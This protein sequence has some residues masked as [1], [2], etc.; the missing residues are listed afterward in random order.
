MKISAVIITYNEAANIARC[1]DAAQLVADEIIIVDSFSKDRT[2]SI[3]ETYNVRFFERKFDGYGEQKNWGNAQANGDFILSLDADEILSKKLIQDILRHKEKPTHQAFRLNRLTNFSGTWVR[4]AGWYPD[5]KVRLWHK[6]AAVWIGKAV[7]E[8]LE[9]KEGVKVGQLKGDLLHYSF[10]SVFDYLN[11]QN[12]YAKL[13]VMEQ[14][15]HGKTPQF[16][17]SLLKGFYKFFLLYFLKL[18]FVHGYHGFVICLNG[19]G[20]YLINYAKYRQIEHSKTANQS[21]KGL[22]SSIGKTGKFSFLNLFKIR[23][24]INYYKKNQLKNLEFSNYNDLKLGGIAAFWAGVPNV[25]FNGNEK[26]ETGL[27]RDF[28]FSTVVS[29][30]T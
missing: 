16:L 25:V 19:A 8:I 15:K 26:Q 21:Q 29:T 1:L 22:P 23:F 14:L 17:P 18:G 13:S 10:N 6:D 30:R 3:C 24:L 9:V 12:K 2:K 5:K 27:L 4:F 11:R 20:K 7:H 28:L